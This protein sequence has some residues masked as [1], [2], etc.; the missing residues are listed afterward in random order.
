MDKLKNMLTT[1]E[2]TER[3]WQDAIREVKLALNYTTNRVT[4]SS[5]LELLIGRT[6]KSYDLS[7]LDNIE[8]K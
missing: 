4:N 2:T 1:I 8:E 7:L 6:A 5:L 3:A